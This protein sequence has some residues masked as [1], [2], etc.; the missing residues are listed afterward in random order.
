MNVYKCINH[1]STLCGIIFDT[2]ALVGVLNISAR[3]S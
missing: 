1:K 3:I 2:I